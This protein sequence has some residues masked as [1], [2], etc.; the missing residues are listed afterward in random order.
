MAATIPIRKNKKG[1][2]LDLSKEEIR[3]QNFLSEFEIFTKEISTFMSGTS[4]SIIL[5]EDIKLEDQEDNEILKKIRLK[6]NMSN[7]SLKNILNC[8]EEIQK[9]EPSSPIP[10][11]FVETASSA[12]AKESAKE[13]IDTNYLPETL[14]VESNLRSGQLIR[15]PGNVFVLGDVNPSAEIIAAGDI[16]IWGT[17]RGV[18]HA[19]S[20]GDQTAKI[21]AMELK[22]GQVRIADK[23]AT[24]KTESSKDKKKG[25]SRAP[26]LVKIQN[27]EIIL[28][29]YFG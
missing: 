26:E 17:L 6:L 15:Y 9:Q 25:D 13:V 14:Y 3:D 1:T 16:V 18:A 4:V 22:T 5:P 10:E 29:R 23:I 28:T 12:Q 2:F 27:N 19:G 20:D 7:I 8:E 21:I 11:S 24:I